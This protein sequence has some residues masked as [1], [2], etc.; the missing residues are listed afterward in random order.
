MTI[1]RQGIWQCP[2]CNNHEVWKTRDESTNQIDRKC[3]NCNKRVRMTLDRSDSGKGRKRGFQIW[4]RDLSIDFVEIIEEAKRRNYN[5]SNES[6]YVE[7]TAPSE[8]KPSQEELPPIWG[9]NWSP[10][11]H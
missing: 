7:I 3:T 4:E 9:A 2:D 8:K 10:K 1:A 6:E 5:Q 11:N